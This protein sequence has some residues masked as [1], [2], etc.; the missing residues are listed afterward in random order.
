VFVG[1]SHWYRSLN[2]S[3]K[4]HPWRSAMGLGVLVGIVWGFFIFSGRTSTRC[5]YGLS[6]GVVWAGVHGIAGS[7]RLPR[8]RDG[9]TDGRRAV[10]R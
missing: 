9:A 2:E 4:A 8:R 5:V 10:R 7:A 6:L 3:M 1:P